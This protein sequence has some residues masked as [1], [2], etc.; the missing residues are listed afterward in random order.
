[1]IT[2]SRLACITNTELHISVL[3]YVCIYNVDEWKSNELKSTDYNITYYFKCKTYQIEKTRLPELKDRRKC[4]NDRTDDRKWVGRDGCLIFFFDGRK[5][6][7][8]EQ[9]P[10]SNV[11]AQDEQGDATKKVF[12]GKENQKKFHFSWDF[13]QVYLNVKVVCGFKIKIERN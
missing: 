2:I 1:M 13:Q 7:S 3:Q 11:Y 8:Q 12:D 6:L 10:F 9:I 5:V 4:V